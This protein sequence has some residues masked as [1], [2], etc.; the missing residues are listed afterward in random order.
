MSTN[1]DVPSSNSD[2]EAALERLLNEWSDGRH[3]FSSEMIQDGLLRLLDASLLRAVETDKERRYGHKSLLN[4]CS[5]VL[6]LAQ[7]TIAKRA[8]YLHLY[9]DFNNVKI[10]DV[11]KRT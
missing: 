5:L 7:I 4:G 6:K 2:W 9:G 8:P 1:G 3:L 10:E 11:E